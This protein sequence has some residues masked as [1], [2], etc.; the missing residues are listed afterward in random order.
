MI[1]LISVVIPAYNAEKVLPRCLDSVL[2]QT[3]HNIEVI[4]INDG[5]FDNTGGV[6]DEYAKTDS[7]VCVIHQQNR[8]V[9]VARNNGLSRVKGT[10]VTFVDSDDYLA[11]QYLESLISAGDAD[12]IVGGYKTVGCNEVREAAYSA[13][14][15]GTKGEVKDL[16]DKH[17]TDMTFLCP[18]GK[19]FRSQIISE[20]TMFFDNS[21]R[22]GEDTDFV[23]RYLTNCRSIALTSGQYYN[24]YTEPSDFK[25][26]IKGSVAL[27]TIDK[28]F[29]SLDV[30]MNDL[31][32][33]NTTAKDYITNYYIWLFKLY[34]K[35]YYSISDI[36]KVR[37]FFRDEVIVGYYTRNRRK[38]K[39]KTLVYSLIK[40]RLIPMLYGIIKLYY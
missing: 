11:P 28:L 24:Y 33:D 29:A 10:W 20:R 32:W 27:D 12:L 2:S 7:R 22:I 37:T 26:A 17:I 5:S 18:W 25:Y 34:I 35:K 16:L 15:A 38:S 9:S 23:W 6:A 8:G 19:L 39:D 14:F 1:Q 3:Y 4:V 40:L 36:D 21:M 13:V 31:S 30:L